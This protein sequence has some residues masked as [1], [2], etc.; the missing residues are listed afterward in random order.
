MAGVGEAE[1]AIGCEVGAEAGGKSADAAIAQDEIEVGKKL[2]GRI[3]V[4]ALGSA[5][6][7]GRGHGGGRAFAA[8]VAEKDALTAAGQRAA[9]IEV[10]ADFTH[11]VKGDLDTHAGDG[12]EDGGR[13]HA[14][15]LAGGLHF[16]GEEGALFGGILQLSKEEAEERN[17]DGEGGDGFSV[18]D[19]SAPLGAEVGQDGEVQDG[20]LHGEE[21]DH[22]SAPDHAESGERAHAARRA[23]PGPEGD[24]GCAA[25]ADAGEGGDGFD[26]ED[27]E[28]VEAQG[29]RGGKGMRP[30]WRGR[31]QKSRER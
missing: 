3:G 4:A 2:G 20:E 15:D 17:H 7:E 8:D 14:L 19:G 5:D 29:G 11:G 30:G 27:A 25:F 26:V 9:E 21:D 18:G 23:G 13:E 22:G 28:C 6:E 16:A 31:I 10:S 24:E 1:D 12:V